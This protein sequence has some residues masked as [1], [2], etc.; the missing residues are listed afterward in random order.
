MY[1]AVGQACLLTSLVGDT[2]F[3]IDWPFAIVEYRH[4][5]SIRLRTLRN[6]N[7][8]TDALKKWEGRKCRSDF[9]WIL[10][11]AACKLEDHLG[12]E[13]VKI[14]VRSS[15]THVSHY[16]KCLTPAD[17]LICGSAAQLLSCCCCWCC[18]D[19]GLQSFKLLDW[20][21]KEK[22]NHFKQGC[23]HS[24]FGPGC[25]NLTSSHKK[26][27]KKNKCFS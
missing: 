2:A 20:A 27:V 25:A 3:S 19:G 12:C 24:F 9:T 15:V 5:E 26:S 10:N 8:G 23:F 1:L 18:G 22:K 14:Y 7:E 21:L 17:V 11:S 13:A 4:Q 6:S 16:A